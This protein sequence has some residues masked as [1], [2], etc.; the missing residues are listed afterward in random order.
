MHFLPLLGTIL[1]AAPLAVSASGTLGF[2]LGNTNPDGSCKQ[3]SDFEADFEALA[4]HSSARLVRTY[5][6][7]TQYGIQCN[8]PSQI[9]PAAKKTGFQVL[10]GMWPDGGAYA[11]EKAPI[12]N[13]NVEQY[14]DTL[15]GITVGSEGI[16]RNTYTTSQLVSW[17]ADMQKT[18]PDVLIGTADSWEGWAN[19]TMDNVIQSGIKLM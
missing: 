2:C 15:Y 17:M 4:A 7:T 14:G 19:G 6:S 13:A 9:L 18:F 1:A 12:V 3:T 11:A 8:T 16:Y 10:L 5:S